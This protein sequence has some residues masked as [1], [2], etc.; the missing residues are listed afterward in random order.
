VVEYP[1]GSKGLAQALDDE[2]AG[3]R[4]MRHA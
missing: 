3:R 2:L 1:D 4:V